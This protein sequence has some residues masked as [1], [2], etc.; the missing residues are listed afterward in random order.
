MYNDIN[1]K[2]IS[3]FLPYCEVDK[4]GKTNKIN[5]LE[6]NKANETK[7]R[8]SAEALRKM[9]DDTMLSG[10]KRR[11]DKLSEKS[12]EVSKSELEAA[13]SYNGANSVMKSNSSRNVVKGKQA[14][15]GSKRQ[16]VSDSDDSDEDPSAMDVDDI[17]Y[18]DDDKSNQGQSKTGYIF[19]HIT[20]GDKDTRKILFSPSPSAT[21][22]MKNSNNDLFSKISIIDPN[23]GDHQQFISVQS[24]AFNMPNQVET[25]VTIKYMISGVKQENS[26]GDL[27]F[28]QMSSP[29]NISKIEEKKS[30]NDQKGA[31]NDNF[32]SNVAVLSNS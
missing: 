26:I 32:Q 30:D 16:K 23:K 5:P 3:K 6:W 11:S 21:D 12:E 14:S 1:P 7:L 31:K 17:S 8:H 19:K 20:E 27:G 9:K 18:Y 4:D 28:K 29:N 22:A 2:D 10:T 25:P 24:P 13:E 15:K